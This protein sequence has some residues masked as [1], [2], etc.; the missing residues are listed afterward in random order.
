[1]DIS[2]SYYEAAK[3]DGANG[4]KSFFLIT[5]PLLKPT[6]IL[7]AFL[8]VTSSLCVM[9]IIMMMT[10]G[11][12]NNASMTLVLYAYTLC[13]G[14]SNAGF[15]MI[16]EFQMTPTER[17]LFDSVLCGILRYSPEEDARVLQFNNTCAQLY[18]YEDNEEFAVALESGEIK[19]VYAYDREIFRG[20]FRRCVR[21]G[22]TINF[23]H[24]I[25]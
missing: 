6:I 14:S 23:G 24:R 21:S 8:S 1:M 11:G 12:P 7:A 9:D 16:K 2:D 3:V 4:I 13:F 5:L 17:D 25:M 15:A 19:T 22:K 20:F 10:G 18:G